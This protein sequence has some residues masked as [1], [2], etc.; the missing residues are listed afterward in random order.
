MNKYIP[1]NNTITYQPFLI[2]LGLHL[3]VFRAED[4]QAHI[5]DAYCP[6]MG[7]NLAVGG[8]VKGNCLECPFHGWK[9]RGDDGKCVEIPYIS[10]EDKS[11]SLFSLTFVCN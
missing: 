8:V 7:A 1:I 10:K 9:F 11:K 5:I 6:H 3:A 4:G 2:V